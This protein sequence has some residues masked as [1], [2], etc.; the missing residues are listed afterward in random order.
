MNKNSYHMKCLKLKTVSLTFVFL[1]ILSGCVENKD[2]SGLEYMPDMYRS[3]AV[4]PYVDYAEIRGKH[5]EEKSMKLSAMV[6][7]L[8]TIPY[9]GTDSQTVSLMLPYS[10]RPSVEFKQTHGLTDY[11]FSTSNEY[12]LAKMDSV[13]PLSL[14]KENSEEIL[15]EGKTLYKSMCLHCHGEKGDGNG[16]MVISGAYNGVPNYTESARMNLSNGQIFYSIYYG[17]GA[18]GAH[19]PLLDKKEIWT[20]VHYVRKFQDKDYGGFKVEEIK[21]EPVETNKAKK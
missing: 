15:K 21:E 10:R 3:P 13:N 7:P 1:Y 16:P 5:D 8:S 19:G 11:L 9:H 2:S 20:L 12:E 17:K 18:M 6:P 14:T 4:E